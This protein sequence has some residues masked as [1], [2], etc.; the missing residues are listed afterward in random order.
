MDGLKVQLHSGKGEDGLRLV[1]VT[2]G[3]AEAAQQTGALGR[4]AALLV[5]GLHV[6]QQVKLCNDTAEVKMWRPQEKMTTTRRRRLHLETF[7]SPMA[8]KLW[9]KMTNEGGCN[10]D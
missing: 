6:S 8:S 5:V 2:G 10:G 3:A 1:V 7:V 4:R 9:F